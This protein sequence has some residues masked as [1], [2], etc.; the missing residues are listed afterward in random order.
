MFIEDD[1]ADLLKPLYDKFRTGYS[2]AQHEALSLVPDAPPAA[3]IDR[4]EPAAK[5]KPAAVKSVAAPANA[6]AEAPT[7][8]PAASRNSAN[9]VRL[10]GFFRGAG[11]N[12]P[13]LSAKQ[14]EELLFQLG[15]V[16]RE[17]I[18]GVIDSLHLRALQKAQLKQSNTI[19]QPRENNRLKFSANFEEGF[20]R[21]F[22]DD[23]DQYTNP[24][25]SVR[26]AF[27]DI[28]EHQRALLKS[29]REALDEYLDRLDPQQLEHRACNG[30]SGTLINAANK[31]K[32]WDLYKEVYS[33]L[34]NRPVDELPQPFLDALANAYQRQVSQSEKKT[35]KRERKEAS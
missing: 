7:A 19:I 20:S 17:L 30:R 8:K 12:S 18:V 10:D 6:Q 26:G 22:L 5:V 4:I 35:A 13:K 14:S 15:Q 33:I 16:M 21:L 24:V 31:L 34:G 1:D 25:E 11:I 28:K 23:S 2:S 9:S 3:S 29:T 27:A 32:Y